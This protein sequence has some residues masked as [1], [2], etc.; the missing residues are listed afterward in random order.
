MMNSLILILYNNYYTIF[1][2]FYNNCVNFI[3]TGIF[4]VHCMMSKTKE[5][6]V[7]KC[8]WESAELLLLIF[9]FKTTLYGE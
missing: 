5:T 4:V 8:G 9:L 2:T 1:S 3:L 7:N 6:D